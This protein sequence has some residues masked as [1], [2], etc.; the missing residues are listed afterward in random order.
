LRDTI[1]ENSHLAI[2]RRERKMQGFKP[3]T[4]T[5]R[6]LETHAA[7]YNVFNLQRHLIGRN[8]LRILRTRSDSV[9]HAAVA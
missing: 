3:R 6:F 8:T 1:A 7:I 9:W 5:Q 2:R 4:S